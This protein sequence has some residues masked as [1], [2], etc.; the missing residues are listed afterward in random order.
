MQN[1]CQ[2]AHRKLLSV[3]G[4]VLNIYAV[5]SNQYK[6]TF[7]KKTHPKIPKVSKTVFLGSSPV[8]NCQ[9]YT[10][11]NESQVNTSFSLSFVLLRFLLLRFCQLLLSCMQ[12][13]VSTAPLP[14]LSSFSTDGFSLCRRSSQEGASQKG[15]TPTE[16]S[17][18]SC[19]QV[20]NYL[21]PS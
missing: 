14:A 12:S 9:N 6:G 3:L 1:G 10:F 13:M 7:K 4:S 5:N 16:S 15:N 2:G 19:F 8:F 11:S 17:V 18:L 20:A 21:I